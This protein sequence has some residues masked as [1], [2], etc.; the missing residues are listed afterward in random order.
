ML[1]LSWEL[2]RNQ[3]P[4]KQFATV[5]HSKPNRAMQSEIAAIRLCAPSPLMWQ[6]QHERADLCC[7]GDTICAEQSG[8]DL[9]R[10]KTAAKEFNLMNKVGKIIRQGTLSIILQNNA[11]EKSLQVDLQSILG[12]QHQLLSQPVTICGQW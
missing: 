4:P 11:C 7:L 10:G 6:A 2:V 8:G 3:A 5:S 9:V 1:A 12:T